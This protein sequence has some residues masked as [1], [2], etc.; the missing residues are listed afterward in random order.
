[1]DNNIKIQHRQAKDKVAQARDQARQI[2]IKEVAP[3]PVDMQRVVLQYTG[4]PGFSTAAKKLF[5]E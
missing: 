3:L 1:M 4:L 2:A 5:Q